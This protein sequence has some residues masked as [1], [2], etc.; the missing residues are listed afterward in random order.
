LS[1]SFVPQ[2]LVHTRH[3]RAEGTLLD[4]L[5]R[6]KYYDARFYDFDTREEKGARQTARD[7]VARLR[8]VA[9]D[10]RCEVELE[11]VMEIVRRGT[12]AELQRAAYEKR[13]S[14][15]D[16]VAYLLETTAPL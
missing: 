1:T 4:T 9:Q 12:G 8:P 3:Q 14:L 7:L 5:T 11:G 13:G 2:L 16:V 15:E 6:P 10:L